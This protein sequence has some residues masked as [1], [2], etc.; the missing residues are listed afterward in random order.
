MASL[1]TSAKQNSAAPVG[2]VKP[3]MFRLHAQLLD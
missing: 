3:T 2:N 1:D